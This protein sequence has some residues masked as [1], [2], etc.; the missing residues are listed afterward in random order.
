MKGQYR[1]FQLYSVNGVID[2]HFTT[3]L[4]KAK[5][6]FKNAWDIKRLGGGMQ[7]HVWE[8]GE[9]YNDN[10]DSGVINGIKYKQW[11]V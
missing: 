10:Y 5:E 1:K 2:S 3:S 7:Y 9:V 6:Y 11:A 4:R 8:G